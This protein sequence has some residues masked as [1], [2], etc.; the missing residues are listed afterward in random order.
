MQTKFIRKIA[1]GALAL[2]LVPAVAATASASEPAAG[3]PSKPAV[4]APAA[5]TPQAL[6]QCGG[7]EKFWGRYEPFR[8]YVPTKGGSRNCEISND[9]LTNAGVGVLQQSLQTCYGRSI[10]FDTVFGPDTK[11][12]MLSVQV[13]ELKYHNLVQDGFYGPATHNVMRH[14][15]VGGGDCDW[16]SGNA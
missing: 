2:A 7:Y 12:A 3:G 14:V 1:G 4:V 10:A 6:D 13:N 5:I 15:K 16:D 8:I 11:Q 9:G